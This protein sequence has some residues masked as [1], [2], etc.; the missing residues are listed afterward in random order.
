MTDFN[1]YN[2]REFITNYVL[3]RALALTTND[4]NV[5][6]S[7]LG[8]MLVDDAVVAWNNINRQCK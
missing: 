5:V 7:S 4:K 8:E 6:Y 1:V 3:N 2:K